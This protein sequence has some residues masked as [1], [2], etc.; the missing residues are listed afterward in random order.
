[1]KKIKKIITFVILFPLWGAGGLMAQKTISAQ[2]V[3]EMI[4]K[5]QSIDLQDATIEGDLDL[6]ELSNKRR[7]KKNSNETYKSNVTAS[8]SFK[9]CTFKGD[10]I[11]YKNVDKKNGKNMGGITVNWDGNGIS[12]STDFD[13]DVI[14]EACKF[15]GL[16]EFKYSSFKAGSKFSTSDFS[17]EANFKYANFNQNALFDGCNFDKYASFKYTNFEKDADFYNV[18]FDGSADFK[19][20]NFDNRSTFKNTTFNGF[21]DFKYTNFDMS[22]NFNNTKFNSGSDF[23]YSKK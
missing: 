14:F 11:A 7:D 6:T 8:I 3:F 12:Y 4:D 15:E 21:A 13:S 17:K 2:S 20:T 16:S 23:K 1:M 19:Y 22:G 9:K 5:G 18:I 10:F